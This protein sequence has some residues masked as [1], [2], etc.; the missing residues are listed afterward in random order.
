MEITQEEID[1]LV[2]A[3]CSSFEQERDWIKKKKKNKEGTIQWREQLS[4]TLK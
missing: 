3:I 4:S 2:D 1:E